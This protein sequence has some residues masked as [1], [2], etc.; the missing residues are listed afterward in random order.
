MRSRDKGN[1]L[2][3]AVMPKLVAADGICPV[4]GGLAS[5]TGRVGHLTELRMDGFTRRLGIECKNREKYPDWP[6]VEL[7]QT[8]H[9]ARAF[10]KLGV[11]VIKK[12]GRPPICLLTVDTLVALLEAARVSDPSEGSRNA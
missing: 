11:H 3:R 5:S 6:W 9:T 7:D 8:D 1:R 2:E 4:L 10:G 12:N